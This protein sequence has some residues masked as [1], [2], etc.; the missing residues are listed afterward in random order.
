VP[1]LA[2]PLPHPGNGQIRCGE[3]EV[4]EFD[5]VAVLLPGWDQA[6]IAPAAQSGFKGET[7][8]PP[9]VV[10]DLFQH[11]P[12][13]LERGPVWIKGSEAGGDQV[14]VDEDGAIGLFGQKFFGKGG[15]P[16][17][18]IM[19]FRSLIIVPLHH[20]RHLAVHQNWALPPSK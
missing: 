3:L 20:H 1:A 10:G 5:D 19:I 8:A 2:Y 6:S 17:A 11:Q 4:K 12:P 16:A 14:G 7:V 9:G 13:G 15:F 18:M